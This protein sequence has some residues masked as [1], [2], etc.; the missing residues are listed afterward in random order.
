MAGKRT[1]TAITEKRFQRI[2]SDHP[3]ANCKPRGDRV[4]VRRDKQKDQSKGGILLVNSDNR[5]MPIG[6]VIRVGP[7]RVDDKGRRV[8]LDLEPGDRVI[9]ADYAGL[10]IRDN[11]MKRSEEDEFVM[12]RDE[13]ILAVL[14]AGGSEP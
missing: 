13:D 6:T 14:P 1:G 11:A 12:L 8:K 10:E 7:G 4:V 9:L 2:E 3:L 5:R